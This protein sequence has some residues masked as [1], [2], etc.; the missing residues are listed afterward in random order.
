MFVQPCWTFVIVE[1]AASTVISP[2]L[3][4]PRYIDG[5][6]IKPASAGSV[7]AGESVHARLYTSAAK[8]AAQRETLLI[9]GRRLAVMTLP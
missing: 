8:A 5:K 3:G 1:R 9:S 4:I 6:T 7:A 2:E